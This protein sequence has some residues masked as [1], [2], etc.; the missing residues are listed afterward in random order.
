MSEK[1]MKSFLAKICLIYMKYIH[2]K[3]DPCPPHRCEHCTLYKAKKLHV[4][5]HVHCTC[6]CVQSE[7]GST[8]LKS[9]FSFL[10]LFRVMSFVFLP[11]WAQLGSEFSLNLGSS[12]TH[13][14]TRP[15]LDSQ[16]NKQVSRWVSKQVSKQVNRYMN[17]TWSSVSNSSLARFLCS[18]A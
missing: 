7:L 12:H 11:S 1:S 5:I 3:K 15:E 4:H 14:T 6:M 2:E 13:P 10:S 9:W 17:K 8:R 18:L 16:G